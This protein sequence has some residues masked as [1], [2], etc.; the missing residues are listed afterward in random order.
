M[1]LRAAALSVVAAP[2]VGLTWWA[3]SLGGLR[4][5]GDSYLDLV[6]SVGSA[7]AAFAL[8]CLLAGAVAGTGWVLARE[9]ELDARGV[10]RLVGLLVGGLLAAALAWAV[11]A[12]L[13]VALPVQ[14]PADLA[15]DLADGREGAAAALTTPGLSP[16]VAAG[17][18]L[19]PFGVGLLV[20]VDTV[21][22]LAW[23]A[24]REDR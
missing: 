2:L 6:Q 24:L 21:R 22:D 5:R 17:C 3:V 12:G 18:L 23:Q 14:L 10:A 20:A 1:A 4:P 15:D 9:E 16:A 8:V 19:W 11:G 13:A 7:D